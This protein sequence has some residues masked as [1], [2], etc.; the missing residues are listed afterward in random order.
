MDEIRKR[1]PRLEQTIQ[2]LGQEHQRLRQSL[3]GII[4]TARTA[5][6][7]GGSLREGVQEW[8]NRICQHEAREND[9]VQSFNMDIGAED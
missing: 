5:T 3:D 1:E 8:I 2:E 7:L 6:S 9:L 4:A